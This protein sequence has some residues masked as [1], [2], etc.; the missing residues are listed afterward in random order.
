[1]LSSQAQLPKGRSNPKNGKGRGRPRSSSALSR[2]QIAAAALI[3]LTERGIDA[4]SVRDLAKSLGV[5]PTAIYHHMTTKNDLLAEVVSYALKELEPPPEGQT[6]QKWFRELFYRYRRAVQAHPAVAPLIG[7]RIVSNGGV[8][9]DLIEHIL[10]KL[11]EAGFDE[12]R[13]IVEAFNV[14]IAAKVGFVT[15]ELAP[16]PDDVEDFQEMMKSRVNTVNIATHPVMA[17]L[18]PGLANSAFILRWE[19][20]TTRPLDSSFDAYVNVV[21]LGLERLLEKW[22]KNLSKTPNIK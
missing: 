11:L 8:G 3:L 16:Q 4:F 2:E 17:R 14:V 22:P 15:L 20:G 10:V 7:A 12:D 6:W 9:P 21:I 1:M 5:Y 13:G 18:L 19:N